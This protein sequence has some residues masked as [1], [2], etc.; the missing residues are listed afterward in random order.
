MRL[1]PHQAAVTEI[2]NFGKTPLVVAFGQERR[3]AAS[4]LLR[5]ARPFDMERR[6]LV[7]GINRQR[8]SLG[9]VLKIEAELSQY[10]GHAR[11]ARQLRAVES[12]GHRV[13]SRS[14]FSY[15]AVLVAEFLPKE[16]GFGSDHAAGVDVNPPEG[17][18][19]MP[20]EH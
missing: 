16:L 7:V 10:P 13:R 20:D 19:L 5:A 2:C 8:C 17:P 4:A 3:N 12:V 18:F 6:D 14:K 9:H 11:R 15:H 1:V